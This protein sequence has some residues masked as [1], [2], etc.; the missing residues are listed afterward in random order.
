[1]TWGAG[2]L[3]LFKAVNAGVSLVQTAGRVGGAALVAACTS[4]RSVAERAQAYGPAP[5]PTVSRP[6]GAYLT[7]LV[8][9]SNSCINGDYYT[10]GAYAKA[11]DVQLLETDSAQNAL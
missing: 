2:F 4:L 9:S 1:M 6:L 5:E 8:E 10:A 11:A 3:P 7:D